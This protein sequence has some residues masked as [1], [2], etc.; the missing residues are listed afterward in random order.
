M[1]YL[2]Q[3]ALP[4]GP[5]LQLLEGLQQQL[6]PGEDGERVQ[7]PC[8]ELQLALALL[9]LLQGPLHGL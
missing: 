2:L 7:R 5:L 6:C 3:C 9:N 8:W 1:V 4:L